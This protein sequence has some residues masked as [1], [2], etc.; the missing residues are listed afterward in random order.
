MMRAVRGRTRTLAPM[1]RSAFTLPEVLVAIMLFAIGILGLASCAT[2]IAT[3][4][5]EARALTGVALLAGNVLDSLRVLPCAAVASGQVTRGPGSVRWSATPS[6]RTVGVSA[7]V[8][9]AGPRGARS[10]TID[11]LLPCDR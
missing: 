8:V 1:R 11:A 4:A 5:G 7:T 3:Q 9:L 10:W 2:Y 6:T